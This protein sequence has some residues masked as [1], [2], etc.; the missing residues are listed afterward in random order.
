MHKSTVNPCVGGELVI[1]TN[2]PKSKAGLSSGP[3]C[4]GTGLDGLALSKLANQ[5]G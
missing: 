4:A 3:V 5:A 1:K 2:S